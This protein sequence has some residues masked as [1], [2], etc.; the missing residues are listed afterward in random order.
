MRTDVPGVPS[1]V[2]EEYAEIDRETGADQ[3][4]TYSDPRTRKVCAAIAQQVA[5]G[6]RA[7][8]QWYADAWVFL[9]YYVGRQWVT[10][11]RGLRRPQDMPR[12]PYEVRIVLN[13]T[14]VAV[15]AAVA[16]LTQHQ[17][18]WLCP[19]TTEDERA[20][21]QARACEKLLD[22][23]W[24]QLGMRPKIQELVKWAAVTGL[25]VARVS[26]DS[27][28]TDL[29]GG[30]DQPGESPDPMAEFMGG[31]IELEV[32]EDGRE[33]EFK[34]ASDAVA[35]APSPSGVAGFPTFEVIS[36]MS[37]VFDP[38]ATRANLSDARWASELRWLHIDEIRERWPDTGRAVKVGQSSGVDSNI[39]AVVLQDFLGGSL[40]SSREALTLDRTLVV[41]YY[42]RPSPRH[43]KGWYVVV[44]GDVVLEEHHELPAG[45][46]PFVVVRFGQVPGRMY[47]QGLVEGAKSPQDVLNQQASA[48]VEMTRLHAAPKWAAEI[49]SINQSAITNRPGEILWYAKGT[50]PPQPIPP[51]PI[52]PQHEALQQA[53]IQHIREITGV[54]EISLGI[55]PGS[56]SGRAA[57]WMAELDAT[58][59]SL[60]TSELEE[61]MS[62]AGGML[63]RLWRDYMPPQTTINVLGEQSNLE[64]W[65]FNSEDITTT[66]VRVVVGS[67][68]VKHPSVKRET[69][70][71]L[72]GIGAYGDIVGDPEARARLLREMEFGTPDWTAGEA[73]AEARDQRE[74]NYQILTAPIQFAPDGSVISPVTVYPW[75]DHAAHIRELRLLLAGVDLRNAEVERFE[76]ARKH[77]AEHEGWLSLQRQ[78]YEWWTEFAP[79]LAARVQ[80]AAPQP[81]EVPPEQGAMLPPDVAP[82]DPST[83]LP[84]DAFGQE[85][86]ASPQMSPEMVNARGPGVPVLD[87]LRVGGA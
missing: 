78:G 71:T 73:D 72:A 22:Y 70:I 4:S 1:S 79:E 61:A 17:P 7:R 33:I 14:K 47:G 38:G 26:F 37:V 44:A 51:V 5:A 60:V 83:G 68:S 59:L 21:E 81:V 32:D 56:I 28:A 11:D 36:P 18:G 30:P 9:C 75:Q 15:D 76:V 62:V 69:V 8:E 10:F 67:M 46:L 82:I 55:V 29:L 80:P 65:V 58:K 66:S 23:L 6:E 34:M 74:E 53:S 3:I 43:P 40:S 25:G 52:S 50:A 2:S 45:R 87:M 35:G 48:Q 20:V 85:M 64:A 57:Q 39:A 27:A 16:K 86:V 63:L 41:F 54:N 84:V 31:S 12:A 49:S 42:E 77:L 13:Y 24:H 19:P